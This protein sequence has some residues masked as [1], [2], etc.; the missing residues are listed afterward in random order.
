MSTLRLNKNMQRSHILGLTLGKN[1]IQESVKKVLGSIFNM[2]TG[3]VVITLAASAMQ[4]NLLSNGILLKQKTPDVNA[5]SFFAPEQKPLPSI[6]PTE[7]EHISF[8]PTRIVIGS[9]GINLRVV[10]VP[11]VNGTWQ[12]NSGVA[13]FAEGTSLVNK[14]D[15]NVGIFAHDRIDG[16]TKIRQLAHG[17]D[18]IVFGNNYKATYK[19]E[20]MAV[21]SPTDVDVF[22]PTK[23][24]TLT[25]TT[26]D[27]LFSEKRYMV[28]AK[29]V[30][31]EKIN[32]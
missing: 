8:K 20:E 15:G 7:T 24:P 13:N 14:K 12:V 22:Y 3:I 4:L 16:F 17:Y 30:K 29:L 25:L 1:Q 27:G 5:G 28:K 11:L 10:S 32:K 26:C 18:I 19:V 21:I 6:A 9:I 31:I 23:E 2:Y